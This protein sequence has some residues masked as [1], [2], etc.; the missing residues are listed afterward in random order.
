MNEGDLLAKPHAS[1]WSTL[2]QRSVLILWAYRALRDVRLHVYA[3]S[4]QWRHSL[5]LE[6]WRHQ[7]AEKHGIKGK[8][9]YDEGDA[10]PQ[11]WLHGDRHGCS[12]PEPIEAW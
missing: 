7:Q 8:G 6:E 3:G 9:R 4:R 2:D 1:G 12:R 5:S 11:Q 10:C